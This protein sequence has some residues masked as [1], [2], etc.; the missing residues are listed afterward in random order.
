MEERLDD[1]SHTR[2][3]KIRL[4]NRNITF[5]SK[6]SIDYFYSVPHIYTQHLFLYL[7]AFGMK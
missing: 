2:C 1:E 6:T 5:N 7:T 4:I 3:L